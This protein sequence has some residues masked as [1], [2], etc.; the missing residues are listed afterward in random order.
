MPTRRERLVGFKYRPH[1]RVDAEVRKSCRDEWKILYS[2]TTFGDEVW[3]RL[4]SLGEVSVFEASKLNP[5]MKDVLR[6]HGDGVRVEGGR[7]GE[8]LVVVF[9]GGLRQRRRVEALITGA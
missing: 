3:K 4:A 2:G 6:V 7:D 8:L 1:G 5:K 9:A